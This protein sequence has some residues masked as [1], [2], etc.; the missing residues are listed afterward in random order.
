MA[1]RLT[2]TRLLVILIGVIL[3]SKPI[4]PEASLRVTAERLHAL[5]RAGPVQAGHPLIQRWMEMYIK[6]CIQKRRG[7]GI[8]VYQERNRHAQ[9]TEGDGQAI[10]PQRNTDRPV[11]RPN[12]QDLPFHE[13]A[14]GKTR[15]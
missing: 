3:K 15:L 10:H 2:L 5:H 8:R 4:L 13:A 7:Y 11:D 6:A 12:R 9:S 1:W 14:M